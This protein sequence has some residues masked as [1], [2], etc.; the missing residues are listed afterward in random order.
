LTARGIGTSV[1]FIPLHLHPYYRSRGWTPEQ[2]PVATREY[3]RVLSLPLWPGMGNAAVAR[4]VA[5]LD[6]VLGAARA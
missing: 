4:V 3:E 5:A 2:L 1:H 6:E